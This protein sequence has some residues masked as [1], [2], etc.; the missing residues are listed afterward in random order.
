M[1]GPWTL[2]T[3]LVVSAVTLIVVVA[4]VIGAVTTFAYRSYMYGRLDD[5]LHSIAMRASKPPG[6]GGPMPVGAPRSGD[7]LA[8][9]DARGLPVGAFGAVLMDGSVTESRVVTESSTTS[10]PRPGPGPGAEDGGQP[11]TGAQQSALAAA[12]TAAGSATFYGLTR[13][14]S[15]T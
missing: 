2:R 8:F 12:D 9:V 15:T 4:A 10:S 11:L 1:A 7:L 5:Q 14:A 3:R 6:G 13:P